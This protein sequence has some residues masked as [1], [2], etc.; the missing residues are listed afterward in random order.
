MLCV[1]DLLFIHMCSLSPK[2]TLLP[3]QLESLKHRLRRLHEVMSK[4]FPVYSH[5]LPLPDQIDIQKLANGG[6]I[7]TD[8]CNQ[9]QKVRSILSNLV[10]G[11]ID[12]D[13]MNHLQNVWFGNMEKA[14]TKELSILL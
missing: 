14:L 7:M 13:C 9:A 8:T 3:S 12:F 10:P 4:K 5:K 6:C 1:Y 2:S 11:S